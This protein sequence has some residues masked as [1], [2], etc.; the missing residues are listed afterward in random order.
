MIARPQDISNHL[1]PAARDVLTRAA[2]VPAVD[3]SMDRVKAIERATAHVKATWP[4]FF[5]KGEWK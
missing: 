5:R 4:E 1:P 3:G 2:R